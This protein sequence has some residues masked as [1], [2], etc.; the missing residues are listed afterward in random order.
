[1]ISSGVC[2][3]KIGQLE[4]KIQ[5]AENFKGPFTREKNIRTEKWQL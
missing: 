1:M 3:V 5:K 2:F 4:A